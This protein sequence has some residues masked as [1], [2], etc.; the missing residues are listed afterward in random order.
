M[1]NTIINNGIYEEY[2]SERNRI[3]REKG[4]VL[5]AINYEIFSFYETEVFQEC[6]SIYS[7]EHQRK[8]RNFDYICR[9]YFG[10][11]YMPKFKDCKLIFG[12]LT[13]SDKVLERTNSDTRRQKVR[14]FLQKNAIHYIANIDFGKQNGREHYHFLA[15]TENGIEGKWKSGLAKYENVKLNKNDIKATKNYLLKLNNHSF[16]DTTRQ[17]RL[18]KDRNHIGFDIDY[19]IDNI[20]FEEYRRFKLMVLSNC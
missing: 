11:E 8:T 12:T 4:D 17:Q 9:W 16:K 6:Q 5:N 20:H 18:I 15:L 19:L 1:K 2:K 13:F 3:Y 7:A 10:M 14:R